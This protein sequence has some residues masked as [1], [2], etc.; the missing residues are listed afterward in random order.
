MLGTTNEFHWWVHGQDRCTFSGG[1][2]EL[3]FWAGCLTGR[4]RS[5][6]GV[7]QSPVRLATLVFRFTRFR[8]AW[9]NWGFSNN[10]VK[11]TRA[12]RS[13][14]ALTHQIS[15]LVGSG[16]EESLTV[17]GHSG[18][19]DGQVVTVKFAPAVCRYEMILVLARDSLV[20]TKSMVRTYI[21]RTRNRDGFLYFH[22][23]FAL[24]HGL[25]MD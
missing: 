23:V 8:L 13:T 20:C 3:T 11:N 15:F 16:Q 24:P 2:A 17:V 19:E 10:R 14:L 5:H 21:V 22:L 6:C 25:Y 12:E 4:L 1:W 7:R 9:P 18:L